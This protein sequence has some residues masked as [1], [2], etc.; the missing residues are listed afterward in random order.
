MALAGM[1]QWIEDR[2]VN[3][4]VTGLIPSQGTCLG[5]GQVPSRGCVKGNHILMFLPL[6]FSFCSPL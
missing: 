6:S 3:Q 4:R 1:A 2:P 5:V